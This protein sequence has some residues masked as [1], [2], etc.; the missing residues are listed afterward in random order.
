M[1]H[2]ILDAVIGFKIS[3]S[4][5]YPLIRDDEIVARR[6][7]VFSSRRNSKRILTGFEFLVN[8]RLYDETSVDPTVKL[9][10]AEEWTVVSDSDG[11]HPL[12]VHVNSFEVLGVPW[13]AAY[14]RMH[15]TIWVPPY[16]QLKVRMRFKTWKGKTVYHCHVLP[17]EDSAM[18]Q[19]F[20]IS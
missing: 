7:V 19:N 1:P 15:D 10:T 5:E 11:S 2:L 12:H 17:H 14:R 8:G 18:I 16:S 4:R 13:D 6:K 9:G 20:L 3:P